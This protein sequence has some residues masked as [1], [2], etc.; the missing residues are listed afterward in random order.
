[1][2]V[3]YRQS[4]LKDLKDLKGLKGSSAFQR[5]SEIAFTNLADTQNLQKLKNI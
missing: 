3:T 5:I 1:M 4:F 2:E